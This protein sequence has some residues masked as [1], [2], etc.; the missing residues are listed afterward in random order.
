MKIK[1]IILGATGMVGEGVLHVALENPAV[2]SVLVIN[3]KSCALKHSKLTEIIHQDF[4]DFSLLEKRLSGYDACFFCMGVS[5]L[6]IDADTYQKI[7]YDLTLHVARTLVKLNPDM[8]FCYVSGA[9]T[10]STE[11]GRSRWARWMRSR[12]GDCATRS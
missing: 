3:R 2:E 11:S 6:G 8:T 9:G 4:L 5:S 12:L 1:A 10:D 7:T